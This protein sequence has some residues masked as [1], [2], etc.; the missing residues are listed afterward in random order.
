MPSFFPESSQKTKCKDLDAINVIRE[1]LLYAT[2]TRREKVHIHHN[3]VDHSIESINIYYFDWDF[4]LE[5]WTEECMIKIV[6]KTTQKTNILKLRILSW[7]FWMHFSNRVRRR[8]IIIE[9][10]YSCSTACVCYTQHNWK[11]TYNLGS[12]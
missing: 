11:F 7:T 6:F 8:R 3:L 2:P 9:P 1:L 10:L 12:R 5:K 4:F